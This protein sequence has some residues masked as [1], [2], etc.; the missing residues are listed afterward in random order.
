MRRISVALLAV[1]MLSVV[2]VA[3][4]GLGRALAVDRA[5]LNLVVGAAG[6]SILGVLLFP[7]RRYDRNLFVVVS[8]GALCLVAASVYFSGGWESPFFVLHSFVVVFAAL[9]YSPR[10]AAA[11]VLL[12]VLASLSPSLSDPD[13]LRLAGHAVVRVP[14]YLALAIVSG[15]MAREIG[16][17]EHLRGEYEQKLARMSDLKERY[18]L[19]AYTDRLT[20]LPNRS[21]FEAC[22]REE[23]KRAGRRDEEFAV[24][25]LDLDDFKLVNDAHGHRVGDEALKL[26][27]GVLVLNA[28]ETDVVARHGGEEFTALL[29]GTGL[30]GAS[31]F[32]GRVKEEAAYHGRQKLGFPLRLSC[33][34]AIYPADAEDPDGLLEAADATMYQAKRRGKGR[35]YHPS[36]K[37]D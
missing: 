9:Y 8:L 33:G 13:A 35:L 27:A 14:A 26:V 19:E 28:R 11:V 15:Y 31:D 36:L 2:L 18:R 29:S 12:T 20:G 1:G 6:L 17:K 25:F 34:V 23:I 10:V 22:L 3:N 5:P 21:R 32:F 7:W 24:L 37:G 4:T 30:A 16:R